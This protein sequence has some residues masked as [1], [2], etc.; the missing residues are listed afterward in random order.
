MG[1]FECVNCSIIL[2][3]PDIYNRAEENP[4]RRKA[5]W[6]TKIKCP[7]CGH[8]QTMAELRNK[9]ILKTLLVRGIR[10]K[11]P[12]KVLVNLIENWARKELVFSAGCQADINLFLQEL[13]RAERAA[14]KLRKGNGGE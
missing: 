13:N 10:Q 12:E 14:W 6:Q 9:M 4:H 11:E 3:D 8:I 1:I 5:S 7:K 2:C